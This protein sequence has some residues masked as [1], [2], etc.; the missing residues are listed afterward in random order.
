M[1]EAVVDRLGQYIVDD[2]ENGWQAA[3]EHVGRLLKASK[4]C[5]LLNRLWK[6]LLQFVCN[7]K[8]MQEIPME[9][10]LYYY[11]IGLKRNKIN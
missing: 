3:D 4:K 10:K 2:L 9:N 8:C 5:W 7:I 6:K 1:I 11:E